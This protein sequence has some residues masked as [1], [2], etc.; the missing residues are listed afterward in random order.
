MLMYYLAG[1]VIKE[2]RKKQRI[3]QSRL[4][5]GIMDRSNLGKIEKGLQI[6]SK[7]NMDA[8]FERL[9][10]TSARFFPFALTDEEHEVFTLREELDNYLS[11]FDLNNAIDLILKMETMPAFK[12]G[13][14]EQYLLKSKAVIYQKK[15]KNFAKARE[16]LDKAI[17]FSIPKFEE[18]LVNTYLLAMGD[19]EIINLMAELHHQDNETDRAIYLLE[20]LM[21][22][23]KNNHMNARKKARAL[24]FVSYSLSIYLGAKKRH[25]EV[26][27]VCDKAIK[28]GRGNRVY[29]LLPMLLFNKAYALY[30]MNQRGEVKELLYQA[31]Y[32]CIA[33]GIDLVAEDILNESL[34]LFGII[35]TT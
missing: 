7:V 32:S 33:L 23:V 11:N 27:A 6:A 18:K 19:I 17:T 25:A 35:I 5:S 13:L 29:G 14:H 21:E 8:L 2:L 26:L 12:S 20:K 30:Y 31:Y 28:A 1:T 15:D 10:N 9:G 34:D 3:S 16:Y 4:A 22:N 24:T